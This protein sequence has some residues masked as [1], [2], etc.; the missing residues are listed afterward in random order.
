MPM[1][2]K[3]AIKLFGR[4]LSDLGQAVGNR[5]KSAICQWPDELDED[6]TNMVIGAAVRRGIKIPDEFLK[7]N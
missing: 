2:K 7:D 5:G 6:K 3:D 4:T 1:N